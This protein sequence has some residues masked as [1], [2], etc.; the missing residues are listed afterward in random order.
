MSSTNTSPMIHQ[1]SPIEYCKKYTTPFLS[2]SLRLSLLALAM[3]VMVT[4]VMAQHAPKTSQT[5]SVGEPPIEVFGSY[6]YLS[7]G[8]RNLNGW[9]GALSFKINHWLAIAGD[10]DGHYGAPREAGE[11]VHVRVHG[12]TFGPHIT[13]RQH[14]RVTPFVVALFGFAHRSE[15]VRG[16]AESALGFAANLGGGFDLRLSPRVSMRVLQVDAAYTQFEAVGTVTPRISTGFVLHLG[17][18]R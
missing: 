15:R 7:D 16:R 2:R 18:P 1:G 5:P 3:L 13:L 10:F 11:T 17:K 14:S 4:S 12:F 6:S 9:T 8:G